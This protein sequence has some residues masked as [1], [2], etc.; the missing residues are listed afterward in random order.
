MTLLK[1]VKEFVVK[2]VTKKRIFLEDE[3][4]LHYRAMHPQIKDRQPW[5]IYLEHRDKFHLLQ[6]QY[7]QRYGMYYKDGDITGP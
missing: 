4:K 7:L 5:D 2:Q 3:I 1:L 6:G